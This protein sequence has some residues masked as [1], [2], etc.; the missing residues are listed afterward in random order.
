M[1]NNPRERWPEDTGEHGPSRRTAVGVVASS[2]AG[3][4]SPERGALA[5]AL[6][7]QP[8]RLDPADAGVADRAVPLGL[9]GLPDRGWDRVAAERSA[10]G[11]G[12]VHH[13]VGDH[14]PAEP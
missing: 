2:L 14:P 4:S 11:P 7:V 9:P 6:A 12:G 1:A 3:A 13:R 10:T 5:A 8:Y